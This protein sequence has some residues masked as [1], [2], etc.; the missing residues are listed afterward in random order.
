MLSIV[1]LDSRFQEAYRKPKSIA[2][3]Q[4]YHISVEPGEIRNVSKF[5]LR[6]LR[7]FLISSFLKLDG[8]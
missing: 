6:R 3:F 1:N 7:K 8:V 4:T 5:M 2:R